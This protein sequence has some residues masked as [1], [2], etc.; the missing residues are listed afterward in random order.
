MA[1]VSDWES[2]QKLGPS[3]IIPSRVKIPYCV[4]M[5]RAVRTLS[6]VHILTVMPA[7]WHLMAAWCTIAE[8]AFNTGDV[9]EAQIL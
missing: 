3:M 7:G 4:A 1:I 8:G 2:W 5:E 9:S 6:P